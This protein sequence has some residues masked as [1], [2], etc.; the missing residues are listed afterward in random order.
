[1]LAG[2]YN[3]IPNDDDTF[4]VRAMA[5]DALMQPESRA[6]LSPRCSRRAG[7]TRCAPA[8]PK[9]G[10]WTFWD[11][12]AGAWQRDAGFRID[13]LLL[14]PLAADRLRRCRRRQG[15][16]RPRKGQRPRADLGA[17]P[18]KRACACW[19]RCCSSG[20]AHA[21]DEGPRFCPTARTSARPPARS[22]PAACWSRSA[23]RL[24][25]RE[26]DA[27]HARTRSLIGDMLARFGVTDTS[28]LQIGWTP[29]GHV[30][31]RDQATGAIE[32]SDRVGDVAAR[33]HARTCATPTAAACPQRSSRS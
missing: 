29:Y 20:P 23:R 11:Y 19:R 17:A 16:S 14:S 15:L 1:M 10:V 2:D 26:D 30:R 28:E 7:P 6:A 33:R 24:D 8:I 21:Q 9:G 5:D 22:S 18:V 27:D 25:A 31:T 3:V 4:S 13:H 12:Q 32:R